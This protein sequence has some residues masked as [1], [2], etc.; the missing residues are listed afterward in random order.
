MPSKNRRVC[1]V[2]ACKCAQMNNMT[3]SVPT[4]RINQCFALHE[5]VDC[6]S[7]YKKNPSDIF[8]C[9]IESSWIIEIDIA[10]CS[11]LVCELVQIRFSSRPS[12]KMRTATS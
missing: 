2:L 6:I 10:R 3:H 1:V 9:L 12:Q 7:I 8:Q 11:K 4:G 5:H